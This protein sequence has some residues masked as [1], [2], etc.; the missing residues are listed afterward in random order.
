MNM[1]E[2]EK[3]FEN[4]YKHDEEL[5][6]R[7]EVKAAKLLGVW[8]GEQLGHAGQALTA[9]AVETAT[10]QMEKAGNDDVIAKVEADLQKAGK[11]VLTHAIAA[12]MEECMNEAKRQVM[13]EG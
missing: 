9:Y 5:R 13:G 11:P 7:V 4:K 3:A 6:F 12:K 1:S 2:R 8:A 10:A